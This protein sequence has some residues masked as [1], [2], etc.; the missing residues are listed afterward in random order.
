MA[1]LV[2]SD[3]DPSDDRRRGTWLLVIALVVTALA[4][5]GSIRFAFV[6]DDIPQI[7]R[8]H[9]LESWST[10]PSFWTAQTWKFLMP[11][12]PGNY[13]RPVFMSWLLL[14]RKLF[15]L[16][17]L[18]MH[19]TTVVVH[20][21]ATWLAF[22]AARTVLRNG[23]QAGFAA[24]LFGLHPVHIES[25]AWV[26]GVTDTLMA[27]FA[28]AAFWAWVR[29]SESQHNGRWI[30]LS[31]VFY[32]LSC[33]AKESA[34]AFPLV[35][36]AYE[37]LYREPGVV[38]ATMRTWP[39]W[40]V[41]A[42]YLAARTLSL[43]GLAHPVF[44]PLSHAVMTMPTVAWGYVRR[45]VWPVGLSAF[46]DTPPV[47]GVSQWRFWL[48]VIAGVAGL[49]AACIVGKRSRLFTFSLIWTAV[50]LAPA[51]GG[52]PVFAAGWIHDRYLY[53]PVFGVC[54]LVAYGVDQLP[55]RTQLFGHPATPAITMLVL[56]AA[57]G[58]STAWQEQFW[59]NSLM[60]WVHATKIAPNSAWATGSLARELANE[61]DTVNARA[62]FERAVKL[63]PD[64]WKNAADYG[65]FLYRNGD[66]RRADDMF[67]LAIRQVTNDAN[68]WLNQGMSRMNYGNYAGAEQSFRGLLLRYPKHLQ[69]H[70]FLGLAL[71]QQGKLE[72]AEE[73]YREQILMH[74]DITDDAPQRLKALASR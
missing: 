55:S 65:M 61:G 68:A 15:G 17:P 70:Y 40:I 67:T 20:L 47:T 45:L 30:A 35:I 64:N 11:D 29:G 26:S 7:V 13:Y 21:L 42:G 73:E 34:F 18:A 37:V 23:R 48:P 16:N 9:T 33:F 32:L 2:M 56:A 4:Y 54:L 31:A 50:F 59:A 53:L 57:L 66:Y 72:E 52:L 71:E 51:I 27:V 3:E 38:R 25:V 10:L 1:F 46:Y 74:P 22:V 39:F 6:F 63:D 24:I 41:G 43:H 60:L 12:L 8:N 49:V 58:G 28:F 19:A 5:L 14:N 69:A 36:I 62:M 44:S